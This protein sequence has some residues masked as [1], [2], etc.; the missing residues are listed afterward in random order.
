MTNKA[1]NV[2]IQ[3]DTSSNLKRTTYFD[4]VKREIEF[5]KTIS[6]DPAKNNSVLN[7]F[8]QIDDVGAI[9]CCL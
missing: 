6:G 4:P 9:I 1:F 2:Q 5:M 3:I 7:K 8:T